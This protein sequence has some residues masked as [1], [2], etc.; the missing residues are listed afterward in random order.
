MSRMQPTD[1]REGDNLRGATR[2]M[3]NGSSGRSI[4]LQRRMRPVQPMVARVVAK[5][6]R[7]V[8]LVQH[9]D[10]GE[11]L[12]SA[13]SHPALRDW[14]LPRTPRYGALGLDAEACNGIFDATAEL[15]SPWKIRY[16]GALS[17][18]KASWSC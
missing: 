10:L 2:P 4:L 7:E 15:A 13:G 14:V 12:A 5:E 9:D 3:M 17:K 18:G 16:L 6:P 11:E 1:S 8:M